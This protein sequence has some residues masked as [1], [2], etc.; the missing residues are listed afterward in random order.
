MWKNNLAASKLIMHMSP[1][2][3]GRVTFI[4][5]EWKSGSQDKKYTK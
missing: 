1:A 2:A 4:N 3:A 5:E